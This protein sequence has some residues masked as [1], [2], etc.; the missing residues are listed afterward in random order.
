[1]SGQ[2]RARVL[3]QEERAKAVS[4]ARRGVSGEGVANACGMSY[5]TL[6]RIFAREPEFESDFLRA[7]AEYEVE[8]V[9]ASNFGDEWAEKRLA[10]RFPSRHGN[11][12]RWRLSRDRY[13]ED[14][15]DSP[16]PTNDS[17]TLEAI[18]AFLAAKKA[19]AL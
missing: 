3:T 9:E 15:S 6:T 16:A 17:T 19:G 12:P 8:L 10:R 5:K 11:D 18:E 1:M 4:L 14:E 7:V 13:A 2:S